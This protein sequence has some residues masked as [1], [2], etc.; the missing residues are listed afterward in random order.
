MPRSRARRVRH[1]TSPYSRSTL[2]SAVD[3]RTLQSALSMM[4]GRSVSMITRVQTI[5]GGLG[6][7]IA[8]NINA[9]INLAPNGYSDW[10]LLSPLYDEWRFLGAEIKFFCQ[11]QNSLTVQSQPFVVVYDNDD[12]TTALSTAVGLSAGLDY[13]VKTQFATVWDNQNFPK[14]RAVAYS[15][16]DPSAGRLWS[17]TAAPTSLPCSFKTICTG[18]SNSTAYLTY[19][20]QA[21]FQYRG[22]I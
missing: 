10:A 6:S 15:S 14:L 1:R 5:V 22:A 7:S 20:I 17:T 18:L 19:T 12:N 16:A 21:V 3:S 11:Q 8:G 2:S 13:R 9:V 4:P